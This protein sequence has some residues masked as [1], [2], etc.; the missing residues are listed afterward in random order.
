MS[1]YLYNSNHYICHQIY[2]MFTK[3]FAPLI[4]ALLFLS[5]CGSSEQKAPQKDNNA[6]TTSTSQPAAS[7]SKSKTILFFGNSL[8]AAYGLEPSEGFVSL[9]QERLDSLGFSYK[10]VNAGISGDRTSGGLSRIGWILERQTVDI[11][12]LELGAN[13]GLQGIDPKESIRNLQQIIDKVKAANPEVKIVIAGMEALPNMGQTYTSRFREIFPKLAKTN[14]AALIPFL[15]KDVAGIPEL[16]QR[17]GIHPTKAGHRLL[18]NNVWEV[19]V[20][21]LEQ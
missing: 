5:A 18:A 3:I 4:I 2:R 12:V 14:S 11:F 6:T 13:D 9:I 1:N 21:L 19:L 8:T 10:A 20:N 17:D 7:A 16:N 15:L